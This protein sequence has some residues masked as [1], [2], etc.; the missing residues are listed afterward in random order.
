MKSQ[1]DIYDL[2]RSTISNSIKQEVSRIKAIKAVEQIQLTHL[3][4]YNNS[5]DFFK[6]L[7]DL[8]SQK[9]YDKLV[10]YYFQSK[11]ALMREEVF[12]YS[13]HIYKVIELITSIWWNKLSDIQRKK[14][15]TK[16]LEKLGWEYFNSEQVGAKLTAFRWDVK[17]LKLP[18]YRYKLFNIIKPLR[19]SY[20]HGG[21]A[22][23]DSL[24]W[25]NEED[26]EPK[27]FDSFTKGEKKFILNYGD[28][29]QKYCAAMVI[30]L[31][32]SLEKK[33][34]DE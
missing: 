5:N 13:F 26:P 27:W 17:N 21:I 9:E 31:K 29:C 4:L 1:T 16:V 8:I 33:N 3:S 22:H 32:T 30:L 7:K 18:H 15:E 25:G 10:D 11:V 19:H 6:R 24:N 14:I 2:I 28:A 23:L 34:S 20:A 12:E